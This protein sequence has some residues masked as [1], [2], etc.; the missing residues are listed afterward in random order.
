MTI[1]E[2]ARNDR[3]PCV[4][5]LLPTQGRAEDARRLEHRV[6]EARR[7]LRRRGVRPQA[8]DRLEELI[9]LIYGGTQVDMRV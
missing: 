2:L 3:R 9:R 8:A 7:L 6:E 1:A 5:I 4:S